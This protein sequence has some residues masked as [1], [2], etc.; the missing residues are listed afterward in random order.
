M[1]SV[2]QHYARQAQC[3]AIVRAA[4]ERAISAGVMS[5]NPNS[6]NYAG[7]YMYMGDDA[8][9]RH[10]FKHQMSRAYLAPV[11]AR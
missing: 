11:A 3:Q 1:H 7:F 2:S 10:L 8:Q 4:F 9:G 5:G 6:D